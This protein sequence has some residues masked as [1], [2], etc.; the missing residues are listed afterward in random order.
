MQDNPALICSCQRHYAR[1]RP[2]F[3]FQALPVYVAYPNREVP[4]Y[5]TGKSGPF[6]RNRMFLLSNLIRL[7]FTF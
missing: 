6:Y 1:H 4:E 3:S 5:I 7:P 2:I